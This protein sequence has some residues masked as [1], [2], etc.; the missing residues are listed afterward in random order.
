MSEIRLVIREQERDW[1]GTIHASCADRA[2]AALSADPITLDELEAAVARFSKPHADSR[3]FANLSPS[4][5]DEPYDAGLIVIDLIARLIVVNSTYSSPGTSGEI[6]YHDGNCCTKTLLPYHLADD[7]FISCNGLDWQATADERRRERSEQAVLDV[8]N[9]FYGRPLLEFIARETLSAFARRDEIAEAV[10]ARRAEEAEQWRAH[11]RDEQDDLEGA[12][13][14]A[15]DLLDELADEPG[16]DE[17]R[18]GDL[19]YDALKQIHAAWLLTPRED[20]GGACPREI[21]LQQRSHIAWDMQDRCSQW[22]LQNACP[23]GLDEASHAYLHGGFGTH[24]LV[25]YYSLVREL[26]WS[27]WEQLAERASSPQGAERLASLAAGDFLADEVPRLEK[28]REAWLDAPD[29]ELHGRTPRSV[30]NRERARLPEG[31]SGKEAIVDPDC[32]CCQMLADMP[33]PAFW[34]LDGSGMDDEFAFDMRHRTRD[35]WE[36]EQQRWE[37]HRRQFDA[38]WAERTRLGVTNAHATRDGSPSVWSRSLDID[39]QDDVPLGA[40]A[41]SVGCNLAELIVA[42]RDGA[43]RE[44]TPPAAQRQI[45]QLNRDFGNLREIL[46]SPDASLIEALVEPVLHRCQETLAEVASAR[47]ELATKCED[48]AGKFSRLLDPPPQE[49][50]WGP[51]DLELPF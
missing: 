46:Q 1:S 49:P 26:L 33:G 3:Y 47:P 31:I 50:D 20:L 43:E 29:V 32:P 25:E 19:F 41:F 4:L 38:E 14:D 5:C 17:E 11:D 35:E 51:D 34:H 48:L 7:W 36:A 22:S 12:G 42:L 44:Q 6:A 39:G 27:C 13:E 18:Y 2:I 45:D 15:D 23:P 24:E 21:A 8:R 16:A 10:R 9:V 37:E 30:I 28:V 40:R